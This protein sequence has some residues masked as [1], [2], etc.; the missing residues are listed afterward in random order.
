MPNDT[1]QKSDRH[2]VE[3]VR[4]SNHEAFRLLYERYFHDV[5]AYFWYRTGSAEF[6]REG[7]QEV[8]TRIWEHRNRLNPKRSFK[9][10]LLRVAHN[11]S[12]DFY[13]RRDTMK[14]RRRRYEPVSV[15]PSKVRDMAIDLEQALEEL[16][17]EMR[18]MF[19][20]NRCQGF[21][22]RE[23]AQIYGVNVKLVAKRIGSAMGLLRK[24]LGHRV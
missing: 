1:P 16:P 9:A 8:F 21:T 17:Q 14:R 18:E 2:L 24:A 3:A 20:L 23:I 13:R 22:Y 6:A 5:F 10:Y 11:F 12:V 4:R 19:L 15:D 7:S